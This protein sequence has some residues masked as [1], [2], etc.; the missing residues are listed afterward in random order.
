MPIIRIV[1]S[2]YSNSSR[3]PPPPPSQVTPTIAEKPVVARYRP[4]GAGSKGAS[5]AER[6]R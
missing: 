2:L 3:R 4:P 6:L 5:F 1:S